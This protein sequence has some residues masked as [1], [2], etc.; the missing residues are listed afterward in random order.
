MEIDGKLLEEHK[1][2]SETIGGFVLELSGRIP[3]KGERFELRNFS[4]VVE[5]SDNKRVRRV[6]L[7]MRRDEE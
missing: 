4:F 3:R 6:K 1:G 2:D 5:A 7:N